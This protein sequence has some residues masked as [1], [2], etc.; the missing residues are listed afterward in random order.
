MRPTTTL[1]RG[2]GSPGA[3]RTNIGGV[4][5][6]ARRLSG[7]RPYAPPAAMPWDDA[8]GEPLRLDANEGAPASDGVVASLA[9]I[10]AEELRRYP[11][12]SPLERLI[13]S[14]LGV[15]A[16]RVVVTN[17]GDDAIDRVCR[18]AID[19]GDGAVIHEPTFEMIARGVR[20]AGGVVE[21]VAWDTGDFPMRSFTGAIGAGARLAA[22]V[23]PNN[24]T[25]AAVPPR[26]LR[27]LIE[28]AESAGAVLLADL[29]Y[30][31]FADDDPTDELLGSPNA[32]IVRTFSKAFGL[33]GARVGYAIA[34]PE[35][36]ERLRTVGGPY[37][38]SS[39][40]LALAARALETTGAP[41][42]IVQRI[43]TEREELRRVLAGLGVRSEASSANFV[44]ARSER[45]AFAHRAL[46]SRGVRVRAFPGGAG[47]ED[48]LRVTLPGDDAAFARLTDALRSVFA[49]QA[50]LF[51]LDGVIAD[52]SASYRS[53][54]T[55][56]AES[57]GVTVTRDEIDRAK[58]AGNANNDWALTQRLIAL[59]GVE[60]D[61]D[62]V[63]ARFQ[64][65]YLGNGPDRGLRE[66]E[67][68]I[69]D[70]S[71]LER[72]ASRWPLGIVTGRP[73]DEARWFLERAGIDRLFASVVAMEDAPAKPC[74]EP[75]ALAM[76]RLGVTRA[77]LVGDTPDDIVAARRAGALPIGFAAP[78]P[79][80]SAAN[81]ALT[82]HTPAAVV[83]ELRELEELLP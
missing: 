63:T 19:P 60:A 29:A 36:A 45:A 75:V 23:S 18:A 74:P 30:A 81:E 62:E 24:P 37:P 25:G 38:C 70:R 49:P 83:R 82:A 27:S 52:V 20:L 71:T 64:T 73:R 11:D 48:A 61:L 8:D 41:S 57:F 55:E 56:T 32:V 76:R 13:A 80:A 34:S 67:T 2:D 72:L 50:L 35:M 65:L 46:A 54:I 69:P 66:C 1:N 78:G 9:R 58:A 12:A 3:D 7:L 77:W 22:V 43:R 4:P 21:G 10:T 44:L 16:S 51:D 79:D 28:A 39:V 31:E 26:E 17:G 59:G 68:L 5:R 15:E 53:A 42:V 40:S 33:A 6:A 47:L 14:R